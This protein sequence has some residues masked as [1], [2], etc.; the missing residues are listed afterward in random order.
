MAEGKQQEQQQER[1]DRGS[2]YGTAEAKRQRLERAVKA[3]LDPA[4]DTSVKDLCR[5]YG[6][7]LDLFYREKKEKGLKRSIH[8]RA[9]RF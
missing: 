1:R 4:C 7:S 2:E 9:Y 5:I 3:Y 8:P 6:I